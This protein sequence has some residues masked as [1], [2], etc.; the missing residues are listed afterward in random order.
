MSES[1]DVYDPDEWPAELTEDRPIPSGG[2]WH[3]LVEHT[4]KM[5]TKP[6]TVVQILDGNYP[7]AGA[8][9]QAARTVAAEFEPPDPAF[10]KG[11]TV[12]RDGDGFLTVVQGASRAFHFST[13]VVSLLEER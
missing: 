7:T 2:V 9:H 12:Y 5:S 1:Y 10:S 3:V 8:A 13:R 11:R 6:P 4:N